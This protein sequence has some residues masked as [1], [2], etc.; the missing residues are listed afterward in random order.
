MDL[1]SVDQDPTAFLY[2]LVPGVNL[3]YYMWVLL[4]AYLASSQME[5]ALATLT[6][7]VAWYKYA[8]ILSTGQ[9]MLPIL[10]AGM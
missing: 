5:G 1:S 7:Y 9:I 4:V 2:E 8:P 3:M 10:C 6:C